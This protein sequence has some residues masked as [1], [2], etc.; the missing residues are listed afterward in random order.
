MLL[1]PWNFPGKSTGVGC[2]FLLQGIFLTQGSNPGLPHC[3][4]TLYCLSY[5]GSPCYLHTIHLIASLSDKSVIY[6]KSLGFFFFL[7]FIYLAALGLSCST[8]DFFFWQCTDFLVV[9]WG[10]WSTGARYL[11]DAGFVALRH[12][13]SYFPNQGSNLHFLHCKADS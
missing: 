7:I 4:Q 9:L 5:Q 11:Q 12:V 2:H 8:R 13:G 1:S 10:L 3:R 6:L